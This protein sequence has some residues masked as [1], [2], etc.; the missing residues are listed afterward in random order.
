MAELLAPPDGEGF[1][2]GYYAW[3]AWKALEDHARRVLAELRELGP[4]GWA[5]RFG[6]PPALR[7]LA[8]EFCA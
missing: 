7:E 8:E 4:E 3:L 1:L 2:A 5:E 6:S